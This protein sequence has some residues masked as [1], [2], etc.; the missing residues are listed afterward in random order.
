MLSEY[1]SHQSTPKMWEGSEN[2]NLHQQLQ[3]PLGNGL[4]M[5]ISQ[6]TAHSK[7]F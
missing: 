4:T 1:V 5:A 7:V 2:E 6:F 3:E